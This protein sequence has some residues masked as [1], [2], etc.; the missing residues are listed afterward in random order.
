VTRTVAFQPAAEQDLQRAF[1]WYEMQRTGLGAEFLRTVATA[2]DQ[3]ARDPERYPLTRGTFRWLK[4]RRFP[5][6]LHFDFDADIVRIHA[7]LHFRQSPD[8]W[9]GI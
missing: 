8:R 9:P 3:L 2:R 1:T 4:L 7:C 5:Y 6:A